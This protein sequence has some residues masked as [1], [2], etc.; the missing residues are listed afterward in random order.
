MSKKSKLTQE[1]AL[2]IV[3]KKP[4]VTVPIAGRAMWN[5]S[6]NASYTAAE[7]NT[8]GVEVMEIGGGAKGKKQLRVASAKILQVLGLS[9]E[10]APAPARSSRDRRPAAA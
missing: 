9:R 8:L 4:S 10:I 1:A 3:R 7:N 6:D 5:F 2:A